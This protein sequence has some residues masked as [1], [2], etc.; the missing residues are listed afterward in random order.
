M[1]TFPADPNLPAVTT[2]TAVDP[3]FLNTFVDNIN[4]MG[5]A[6]SDLV[7]GVIDGQMDLAVDKGI[8]WAGTL[9]IYFSGGDLILDDSVQITGALDVAGTLSV[10]T[11]DDSGAS[12][13]TINEDI[14][15]AAGKYID[16]PTVK[17]DTIDDSGAVSITV[18]E[19]MEFA[20]GKYVDAPTGKFD[21]IDDSGAAMITVNETIEM[22][23]GKGLQGTGAS[24]L[25]ILAGCD[26]T[27]NLNVTG[28][29]TL[30][31]DLIGSPRPNCTVSNHI[32]NKHWDANT[33]THDEL[34]D[35]VGTIVTDL[36]SIGL[37]Q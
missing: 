27:G 6:L 29:V 4:A 17:V 21:I 30:S 26:I 22:G 15:V 34:A 37:F 36:I 19:N 5:P 32:T 31:G 18:N 13:I 28:N 8:K 10:D 24:A 11:I 7:G 9:E 2:T 16:V 1:G 33:I 23:A 20:A 3:D 25:D 35:V 14:H 12:F